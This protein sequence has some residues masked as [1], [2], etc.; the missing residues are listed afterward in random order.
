MRSVILMLLGSVFLGEVG[1]AQSGASVVFEAAYTGD[2]VANVS[3]GRRSGV[4]YLDMFDAV[5]YLDLE[6]GLGWPRMEAYLHGMG[7][8]GGSPSRLVGNLQGVNN[9]E[10][11]NSWKFYEVLLQYVRVGGRMSVLAGLYDLNT[12]FDV[13][14]TAAL[15]INSS[16]GIGPDFSQSGRNG[17]SIFPFASL[18]VR[19]KWLPT[20]EWYVQAVA[21]DGVPGDPD[22]PRG[23]HVI[24]RASEGA[25]LA[26]ETGWY[27][28]GEAIGERGAILRGRVSRFAAA[29]FDGRLA[30]GAW[31]Y[32][33]PFERLDRP[34]QRAKSR[35]AYVLGE[36]RPAAGSGWLS[37]VSL[38]GRFG[39]AS[40]SVNRLGRY[41]GA[42]VV[43]NGPVTGR[44][45]DQVGLAVASA[46]NGNPFRQVRIRQGQPVSRA[47]TTFELT[48]LATLSDRV[49]V[50][51][52]VQ[53]VI[54]PDTDPTLPD[55]LVLGLRLSV[56]F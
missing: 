50:Q 24:L 42:G 34:G 5:V 41:V 35:G 49:A 55:A 17:P 10:A 48:Y 40:S 6:Q 31:I 22:R 12:E 37:R 26:A 46:H 4:E 54:D 29:D 39:L 20:D 38:F 7:T 13:I 33:E 28:G 56:T 36:W 3:G 21:L 18:G 32:T 47:E 8:Q 25:L 45:A 15:F 30:M 9:I 1:R 14:H 52:D 23:T 2:V 11:P 27:F 16:H 53:Y 43:F 19:M 44:E 51:G